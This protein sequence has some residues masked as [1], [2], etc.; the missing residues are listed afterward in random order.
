[1]AVTFSLTLNDPGDSSSI[2][3]A[4]SA[5]LTQAAAD[6][7]QYLNSNAD[8]RVEV[9]VGGFPSNVGLV[10]QNDQNDFVQIGTTAS[11]ETLFEPWGEYALLNDA[12]VP[13]TPYD[14][15]IYLNLYFNPDNAVV[16]INPDPA[17][18]GPVPAGEYDL[19]TMFLKALGYGLGFAAFTTTNSA[20]DGEVTQLDQYVQQNP[21]ADQGGLSLGVDYIGYDLLGGPAVDAVAGGPVSLV[22]PELGYYEAIEHMGNS[23]TIAGSND[24]MDVTQDIAGESLQISPLDLAIMQEAGVPLVAGAVTCFAAGTQIL[25]PHGWLAIECLREGD[26]VLTVSGSARKIVWIG[27]RRVDC[28]RHP[29]PDQVMPIRVAAHA[30]G[31][32]RPH[33][34][35]LLSPDHAVFVEDVLIPIRLLVN[36]STVARAPVA[37]VVYYH[38]E[39]PRHDVVL[40]EGLPVESYLEVDD[41]RLFDNAGSVIGLHPRFAPDERR[42]SMLWE[43]IGYAPLVRA[44]REVDAVRAKLRLQAS[45]LNAERD[46]TRRS[47][48]NAA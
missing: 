41:R 21:K 6:W 43:A 4:I 15:H 32:G 1:M 13:G 20:P 39:L 10:I 5:D 9:D 3:N 46:T 14:I 47:R 26:D 29:Q 42:V 38:I 33:R 31:D 23:P 2:Y 35:V 48:T 34:A 40:A 28:Q 36:G 19:T 8:I 16:Y 7:S 17:A 27:R 22:T 18:G 37:S 25:T 11:G 45:L 30:F 12:S 44:G 24:I